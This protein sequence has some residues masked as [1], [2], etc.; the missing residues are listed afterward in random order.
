[1][2]TKKAMPFTLADSNANGHSNS[3]RDS[4]ANGNSNSDR[5]SDANRCAS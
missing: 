3:D 1:M 5:D 2:L 4:D